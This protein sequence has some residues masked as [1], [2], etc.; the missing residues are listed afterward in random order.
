MKYLKREGGS[1]AGGCG[2]KWTQRRI[3][4]EMM[5]AGPAAGGDTS[6]RSSCWVLVDDWAL[7]E[8]T[9]GGVVWWFPTTGKYGAATC[10]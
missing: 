1:G 7:S 5:A 3:P 4:T 8:A 9:W 6:P 10:P 2:W